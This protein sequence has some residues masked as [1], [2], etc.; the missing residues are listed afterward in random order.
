MTVYVERHRRLAVAESLRNRFDAGTVRQQER[1]V[2]M[3]K[4]VEISVRQSSLFNQPGKLSGQTIG[5]NWSTQIV[6]DNVTI[7][8]LIKIIEIGV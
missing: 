2:A 6:S 4:A 5:V 7:F 3:P 1:S 8:I